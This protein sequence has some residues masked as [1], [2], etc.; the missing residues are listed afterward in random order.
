LRP[1]FTY[2]LPQRRIPPSSPHL[3]NPILLFYV[4]I[5]QHPGPKTISNMDDATP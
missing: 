5:P 3:G 4:F 1:Y 2:S